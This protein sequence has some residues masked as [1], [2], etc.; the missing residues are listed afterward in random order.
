MGLLPLLVFA[1]VMQLHQSAIYPYASEFGLA[2]SKY[3]YFS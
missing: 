2:K 1:V 3:V